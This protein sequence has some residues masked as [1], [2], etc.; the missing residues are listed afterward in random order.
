[1]SQPETAVILAAGKGERLSDV[2]PD[3]P[4][5]FLELAGQT[6]IERSIKQLRSVGVIEI[7]IVTGYGAEY[8]EELAQRHTDI[9]LIHNPNFETTGSMYSLYCARQFIHNTSFLLL[10]SDLVYEIRALTSLLASPASTAVLMSGFTDSGDEVYIS[11]REERIVTISKDC[12]DHVEEITGELVGIMKMAPN[13]FD[14]LMMYAEQRFKE[15]PG[16]H[17]EY[18]FN[19]ITGRRPVHRHKVDDLIWGEI[20]TSAHL[21][22]VQT[23][24]LPKLSCEWDFD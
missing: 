5:G 4:K 16:L 10:E 6:L 7:I 8:Y 12:R 13:V 18:G 21:T 19:G 9:S 11:T 14:A 1:M 3:K 2:L 22:R 20:D 17:Y 15:D 23:L 24:I